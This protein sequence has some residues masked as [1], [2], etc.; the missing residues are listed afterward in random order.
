M[1]AGGS[2][3]KG[4]SFE[5]EVASR[6]IACLGDLGFEA[7]DCYRTPLSGGHFA[8]KKTDPGDLLIGPKLLEH[9]PFSVECKND[10]RLNLHNFW[11]DLHFQKSA[12]TGWLAQAVKAAEN[13][14]RCPLLVFKKNRT[15]TYAAGPAKVLST[16]YPGMFNIGDND[17][18]AQM[19]FSY[20]GQ[21][22]AVVLLNSLL[23]EL[24]R[25]VLRELSTSLTQPLA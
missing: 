25:R 23:I 18:Y 7:S 1:K 17:G 9:F 16:I 24:R 11:G 13:Q 22:W 19:F 8:A 20:G 10:K 5:R 14:Q 6:L 15:P 2:R 3:R 4:S 12:E 21:M